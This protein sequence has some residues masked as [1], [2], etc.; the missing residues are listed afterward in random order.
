MDLR[1][2]HLCDWMRRRCWDLRFQRRPSPAMIGAVAA[3]LLFAV[4]LCWTAAAAFEILAARKPPGILGKGVLRS[5]QPEPV[6]TPWQWRRAG[7]FLLAMSLVLVL[8]GV[9]LLQGWL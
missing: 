9:W 8:V 2:C 4:A 7:A 1:G 6:L 5:P 3:W